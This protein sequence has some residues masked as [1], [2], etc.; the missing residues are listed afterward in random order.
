MPSLGKNR[1]IQPSQTA[2]RQVDST[3]K[4]VRLAFGDA[5]KNIVLV[6]ERANALTP[7][8][9]PVDDLTDL[10]WPMDDATGSSVLGQR[11]TG[12]GK[13]IPLTL[14]ATAVPGYISEI[15]GR[16][17]Q[18]RD[19][20]ATTFARVTAPAA[21]TY[22]TASLS[23]WY[24]PGATS[25][26]AVLL[27]GNYSPGATTGRLFL[28][29][30]LGPGYAIQ[31]R[32]VVFFGVSQ[33]GVSAPG[34]SYITTGSW[35]HVGCTHDGATLR[36]YIDGR[37]VGNVGAAGDINWAA[38]GVGTIWNIGA[39]GGNSPAT[40][41]IQDARVHSAPRTKEWFEEAYL[42]GKGRFF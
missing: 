27:F 14:G 6:N 30:N 31:M 33:V 40:G 18:L 29:V 10:W 39:I 25:P 20:G 23:C 41:F 16:C 28:V 7:S 34:E 11:V 38:G 2:E 22:A 1:I 26:T 42:R 24:W 12:I 9:M 17:L 8:F 37:D 19:G 36:L 5:Q 3:N 21:P 15:G 4:D 35:H 13:D 32:A